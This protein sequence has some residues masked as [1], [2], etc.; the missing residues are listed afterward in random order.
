MKPC[1]IK[2]DEIHCP[3]CYFINKNKVCQFGWLVL[4][5]REGLTRTVYEE[6]TKRT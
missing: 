3:S 4:E 5:R 2:L 1:P 6:M